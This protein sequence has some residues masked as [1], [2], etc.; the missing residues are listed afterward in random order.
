VKNYNYSINN[1]GV[2]VELIPT[3]NGIKSLEKK[4]DLKTELSL[5]KK[6]TDYPIYT[7]PLSL[8]SMFNDFGRQGALTQLEITFN[9]SKKI[10]YS[11]CLI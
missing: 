2:K 10:I 5:I 11:E 6:H 3:F 1:S 8:P 7:S 4:V 9:N